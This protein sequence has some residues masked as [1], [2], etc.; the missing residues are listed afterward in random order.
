[1]VSEVNRYEHFSCHCSQ[2]ICDNYLHTQCCE[3]PECVLYI[4]IYLSMPSFYI[5]LCLSVCLSRASAELGICI[6]DEET[7]A[8]FLLATL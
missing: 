8:L 6:Y 1:M 3:A 4:N 5:T 2:I 7:L